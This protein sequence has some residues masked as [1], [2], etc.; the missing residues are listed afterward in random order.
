MDCLLHIDA[1]AVLYENCT[2]YPR[3]QAMGKPDQRII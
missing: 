3:M 1:G 2:A